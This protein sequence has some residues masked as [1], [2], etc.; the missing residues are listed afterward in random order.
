MKKALVNKKTCLYLHPQI[1]GIVLKQ[2]VKEERA[3]WFVDFFHEG[4]F[5]ID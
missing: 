1:S 3:R 2:I 4:K 5:V